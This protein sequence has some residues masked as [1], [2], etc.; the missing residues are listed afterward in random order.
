MREREWMVKGFCSLSGD[1][2][3]K[4][5]KQYVTVALFIRL[6]TSWSQT[7][8]VDEILKFDHSNESY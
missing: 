5:T 1:T 2:Q 3:L 6:R 8:S 4:V 7:E